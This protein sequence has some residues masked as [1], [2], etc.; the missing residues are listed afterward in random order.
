MNHDTKMGKLMKKG[1]VSPWMN[2]DEVKHELNEALAR[3]LPRQWRLR[4][5]AAAQEMSGSRG[6]EYLPSQA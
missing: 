3:G 1:A 5:G 2:E 6:G 4:P